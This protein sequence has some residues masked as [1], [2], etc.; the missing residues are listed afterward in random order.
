MTTLVSGDFAVDMTTWEF[1]PGWR[2]TSHSATEFV[3]EQEST[4]KVDTFHGTGFAGFDQFGIPTTGVI[5]GI[6]FEEDGDFLV[7]LADFSMTVEVQ[8]AFAS[9]QNMAGWQATLFAGDDDFTDSPEDDHFLGFGGNDVFHMVNGGNDI[10]QGDF[11]DDEFLLEGEFN[12]EDQ[13]DGGSGFDALHLDGNYSDGVIFTA[14]TM[15]GIELIDGAE[16]HDYSLTLDDANVNGFL[17]ADFSA[18]QSGDNLTFD[19]SNETSSS[20][21]VLGGAGNDDISTGAGFDVLDAGSGGVDSLSGGGGNDVLFSHAGETEMSGGGGNDTFIV[22]GGEGGIEI[23]ADHGAVFGAG[24]ADI[25]IT[26]TSGHELL[27]MRGAAGGADID[28]RTGGHIAGRTVVIG[29]GE[30]GAPD[31]LDLVFAQD[32]TGTFADDLPN[33]RSALPDIFDAVLD[34]Q[35]DALFGVASFRDKGEPS[36][37]TDLGLT[38]DTGAVQDVYD[39]FVA[40]GGGDLPEDQL[41]ALQQLGL[42]EGEVGWTEGSLHVVVMFTDDVFHIAGD[43]PP[44]PNNGDTDLDPNEDYPTIAQ[45]RAALLSL[46]IVPIFAATSNVLDDYQALVDELGFGAVVELTS[47][48]SNIV[49]AVTAA[50]GLA[51]NSTQLEDAEGSEFGDHIVGTDAANDIEGNGGNDHLEGRGGNDFLRGATGKDAIFGGDG[52]DRIVGGDG[53]DLLEG[54]EGADD[55]KF[56]TDEG[57]HRRTDVIRGFDSKE[58]QIDLSY[59]I[60]DVEDVIRGSG[61]IEDLASGLGAFHAALVIR[62]PA[63]VDA[64]G[65]EGLRRKAFMVIDSN[66]EAGFQLGQDIL[67]RLQNP[68]DIKHLNLADF[69]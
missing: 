27:D 46:D 32:L 21:H 33:V 57:D 35:P 45:V 3:I 24:S 68:D 48:S 20:F 5:N 56:F 19:A 23:E 10:A 55:F 36:Y 43:G 44:T 67:L 62:E 8:R 42:R 53:K 2:G 29:S 58:D 41:E 47:D 12:A 7:S 37:Q 59:H 16:G 51:V 63:S 69:F 50:L 39:D 28:L 11:G 40:G 61:D 52:D 14:T 18:L 4:G 31:D 26:D 22:D 54:G 65:G 64:E 6:D 49:D 34:V 1:T 15:S 13:I 60:T 66:G 25:H 38:A 30:T 9:D 17:T